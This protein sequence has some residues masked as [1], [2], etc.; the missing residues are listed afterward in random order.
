MK[1][2]KLLYFSHVSW[3]WIKQ[4]PHFIAEEL[5]KYFEV[6]VCVEMPYR[7]KNRPIRNV[8]DE[9]NI[10]RIFK[11]PFGKRRII[12]RFNQLLF[13]FQVSLFLKKYDIFWFTSPVAF[14]IIHDLINGEKK[15]VYDC[16]DDLLEFPNVDVRNKKELFNA[17]QLLIERSNVVFS[18]SNYLREKLTQRYEYKKQI[19]VVNNAVYIDVNKKKS[20]LTLPA[21]IRELR[22][23]VSQLK[24]LTYIGTISSWLDTDL[25]V[26][27]LERN[28]KICYWLFGPCE[29]QLP[30]C[31]RL[32][33]CGSIEHF[34]VMAVMQISDVMIMPFK[35]N[36][37][38]YSVNP[39]KLYEYILSGKPSIAIRYPESE[40]FEDFVYLYKNREEYFQLISLLQSGCLSPKRSIDACNEFAFDNS[41]SRRVGTMIETIS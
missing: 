27:S 3:G 15:V 28:D 16:M 13:R 32:F 37:L 30:M 41:W 22:N 6:R 40:K 19:S 38:I 1:K 5:C 33:Y 23:T 21:H 25:M 9:L 2:K 8:S 11:L 7:K 35:L 17:E 31:E 20:T 39:V 12:K 18:S 10:T 34:L 36:E 29:I 4:R 26:E 14:T 24:V